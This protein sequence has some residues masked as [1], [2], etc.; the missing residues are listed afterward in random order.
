MKPTLVVAVLALF[1]AHDARA[2]C[3]LIPEPNQAFQSSIGSVNRPFAAPGDALQI[4]VGVGP[5]GCAGSQLADAT[6]YVVTLVFTPLDGGQR[7]AVLLPTASTG[8]SGNT[9]VSACNGELSGGG[10]ATCVPPPMSGITMRG[11]CQDG[12]HKGL[13]CDGD[14]G[15]PREDGTLGTCVL[16]SVLEFKFPDTQATRSVCFKGSNDGGACSN[17]SQCPGGTCTP[18]QFS[19]A[20]PVSIAV[21]AASAAL[22]CGLTLGWGD[23]CASRARPVTANTPAACIDDLFSPVGIC[24]A[25]DSTF[26]HFTALPPPNH[27]QALC[28]DPEATCN[29]GTNDGLGCTSDAGCPGSANCTN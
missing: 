27:Y 29:G 15:C 28:T 9:L 19:L 23:T 24:G 26:G 1:A 16:R 17:A 25:K 8:C 10:T 18:T 4:R 21:T 12:S 7:N 2:A 14:S 3:N 22:P 6:N 13:A 5:S 11:L 20:G